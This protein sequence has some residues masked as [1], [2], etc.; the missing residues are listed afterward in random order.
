[1]TNVKC[2]KFPHFHKA[3]VRKAEVRREMPNDKREM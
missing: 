3:K 1:M 2:Q